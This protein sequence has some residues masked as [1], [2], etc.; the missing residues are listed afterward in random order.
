[1]PIWLKIGKRKIVFAE[2]EFASDSKKSKKMQKGEDIY[3]YIYIP[4]HT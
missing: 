3:I 2:H 4:I 1:M